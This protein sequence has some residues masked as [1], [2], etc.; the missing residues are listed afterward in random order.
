MNKSGKSNLV[1][2]L[3]KREIKVRYQRHFL[4]FAWAFLAPILMIAVFYLVFVKFLSVDLPEV[5]F[6]LYLMSAVFPWTFFQDSLLGSTTTLVNNKNLIKESAFPH[7]FLPVSLALSNAVVFIPA[8]CVTIIVSA[9]MMKGLSLL[10]FFL[11][12]IVLLHFAIIAGLSVISSI[13][14]VR[15]RDIKYI[16]DALLLFLFYL[17]PV[18][19]SLSLPAKNL[20]GTLGKIYLCNPF[21][22]ILN[23]YRISLLKGYYNNV[24]PQHTTLAEMIIPPV[25]LAVI[26]L[27]GAFYFYRKNKGTIND[28]L[29]Y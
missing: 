1:R 21:V 20:P 9:I 13:L 19:Y 27:A 12:I 26:S 16:L 25:I 23:L 15:L 5:P 4:G 10:V 8:M 11:P 2:E 17:T 22:G 24:V 14:Y 6:M 28:Y 3:V 7:Y 18:F 29:S